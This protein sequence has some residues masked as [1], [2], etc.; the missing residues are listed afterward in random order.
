MSLSHG[1]TTV[2]RQ[3]GDRKQNYQSTLMFH[4]GLNTVRAVDTV[5][6]IY[7]AGYLSV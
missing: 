1:S 5:T 6:Y 2:N 3:E 4:I 7:T